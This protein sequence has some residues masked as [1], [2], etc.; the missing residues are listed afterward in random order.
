MESEIIYGVIAIILALGLIT[1]A[2]L[3]P[4]VQGPHDQLQ[5]NG[6]AV[7]KEAP[8]QATI[9][10]YVE[11][12][13]ETALLSQEEASKILAQ[14]IQALKKEGIS[15]DKIQTDSFT[16]YPEY[17]YPNDKEP[18]LLGYKTVYGLKVITSNIDQVGTILDSSIKAGANRINNIEFGLSDEKMEEA[19]IKVIKEAIKVA[20]VKANAMAEAGNLRIGKISQI[21]EYSYNIIPYNRALGADLKSSI[22]VPPEDVQIS[23]TVSVTYNI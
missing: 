9:Y 18:T 16:I 21:T 15:S 11:T 8:D 1:V 5:V 4:S 20:Q 23:A 2:V 22:V 7:I 6:T 3:K 14:V 10:V 12:R 17:Y 13:K 19:K